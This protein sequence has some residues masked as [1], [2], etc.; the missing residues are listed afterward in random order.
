MPACGL[1]DIWTH[2]RMPNFPGEASSNERSEK[3][4]CLASTIL[5]MTN[6]QLWL[7][8]IHYMHHDGAGGC[9]GVVGEENACTEEERRQRGFTGVI[10]LLSVWWQVCKKAQNYLGTFATMK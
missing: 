6:A 3:A 2:L 10:R 1:G 9:N 5:S 4:L 8:T 7:S